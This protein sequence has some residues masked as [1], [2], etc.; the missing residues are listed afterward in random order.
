MR[1]IDENE[2]GRDRI[3]FLTYQRTHYKEYGFKRNIFV[4]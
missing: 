1:I 4:W 2:N 3:E